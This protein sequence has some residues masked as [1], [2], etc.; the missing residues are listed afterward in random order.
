LKKIESEVRERIN[1]ASEFA[2]NDTEPN[3]SE[4]FTDVYR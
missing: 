3:A 1:A 4:L 2:T